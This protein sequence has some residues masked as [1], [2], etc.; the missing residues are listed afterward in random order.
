MDDD[1]W[2]MVPIVIAVP[3]VVMIVPPLM[4]LVPATLSFSAK[5]VP[6]IV[7]LRAVLA[8]TLNFVVESRPGVFD[9]M[10]AAR[11]RVGVRQ[12]W[13]GH[14]HEHQ[15]SSENRRGQ[16]GSRRPGTIRV[17]SYNHSISPVIFSAGT[18]GFG[19]LRSA[20]TGSALRYASI[21][22]LNLSRG[23]LWGYRGIAR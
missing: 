15:K 21:L 5:S 9:T 17:L 22:A 6:S 13:R 10:L 2:I 11:P 16:S 1:A 7:G 20:V 4:V 12:L 23:N 14:S 8:V 3:S 18:R 19:M